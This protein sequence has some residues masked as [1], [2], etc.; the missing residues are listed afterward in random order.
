MAVT[1]FNKTKSSIPKKFIRDW[2]AKVFRELKKSRVKVKHKNLVI[3]FV[4]S[5]EIKKLNRMYRGKNKPTDVLS[6]SPV[7]PNSLGELVLC[8]P[9]LKKQSKEH[10][11]TFNEETGY[12]ILHGILHLLGFDHEKS[13]AKAKKMFALQ[14]KVFEKLV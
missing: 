10:K 3:V 8:L 6:F 1:V 5:A 11:L 13:K 7:E 2:C 9:V 14:D 4:G 12:M